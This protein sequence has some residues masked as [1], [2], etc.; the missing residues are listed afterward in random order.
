M[1][2]LLLQ[3]RF[4]TDALALLEESRRTSGDSAAA[5]FNIGLCY[6]ALEQ[7]SLA[8]QAMQTACAIDPALG[9]ARTQLIWLD[10][11][12]NRLA[13]TSNSSGIRTL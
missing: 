8:A 1:G 13:E 3:L 11:L 9:Q 7:Y 2:T 6:T 5:L 4:H 12:Q 10:S